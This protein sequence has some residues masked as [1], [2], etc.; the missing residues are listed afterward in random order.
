MPSIMYVGEAIFL[1]FSQASEGFVIT[2][3]FLFSSKKQDEK[4]S[5]TPIPMLF[6]INDW[7]L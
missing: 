7:V 5:F 4:F 6:Q 1:R 2:L 3:N